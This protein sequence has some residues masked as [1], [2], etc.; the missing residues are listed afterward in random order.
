MPLTIATGVEFQSLPDGTF[1]IEFF[2]DNSESLHQQVV[3]PAVVKSLPTLVEATLFAASVG[4]IPAVKLL[5]Q[6]GKAVIV[7]HVPADIIS[8]SEPASE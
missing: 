5:R 7:F 6:T 8:I 3:D 4:I 1:Q 2:N